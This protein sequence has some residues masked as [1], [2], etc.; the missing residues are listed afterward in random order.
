M[1]TFIQHTAYTSNN[2]YYFITVGAKL[3]EPY[4]VGADIIR[5][6]VGANFKKI[7][8]KPAINR[9]FFKFQLVFKNFRYNIWPIWTSYFSMPLFYFYIPFFI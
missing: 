3:C 5:P 9:W 6:I 8:Q 1:F 4:F 2:K 7:K